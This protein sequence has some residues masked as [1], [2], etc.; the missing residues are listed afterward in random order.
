M[1]QNISRKYRPKTFEDVVG[2]N[3]IK[4]TLENEVVSG[5]IAHAYLF[6]GPRGIGKTS[7]ARIL[8]KSLK[9]EQR[10]DKEFEPCNKCGSCNEINAGKDMDL[11][12]IDAATHTQVDKVRE[13]IVENINFP[14]RN[15]YK[16]FIIDEVHML[17]T[18][19]FNALLKTLEEPPE[20]AVFVLCTTESHKIP[21]TII[22]RCQRFDF[23]KVSAEKIKDKLVNICQ[24]EKLKVSDEVLKLIAIRSGGYVRDAESLLGQITVLLSER[25]KEITI[26]DVQA[27]LP[28]SDLH[29]VAKIIDLLIDKNAAEGISLV[30]KLINDGVDLERF[31]ED[32]IDYL[33]KLSLVL[34][35]L[36]EKD[37]S[38]VVLPTEI[39]SQLS[40][41]AEKTN[42]KQATKM[43]NVF[44]DHKKMFKQ[45]EIVQLPIE[46]AIIEICIGANNDDKNN[47]KIPPTDGLKLNNDFASA[48]KVER[49]EQ[50]KNNNSTE[51]GFQNKN[52]AKTSKD[53]G[54]NLNKNSH[55]QEQTKDNSGKKKQIINNSESEEV[56]QKIKDEWLNIIKKSCEVNHSLPLMLKSCYPLKMQGNQLKL[57]FEFEIHAK[58]IDEIKR[59]QAAEKIFSEF[60]GID[61]IIKP[62]VV[63]ADELQKIKQNFNPKPTETEAE[64]NDEDINALAESFGGKVVE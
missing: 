35:G 9:C 23:K 22:S 58:Q 12:E 61:I 32:L 36:K 27:V 64:I 46:L 59:K 42:I 17:S 28:R 33:R 39:Q 19:A 57:G 45:T 30:D 49:A 37:P 14:P 25:K 53:H 24:Q 21:E 4:I 31:A 11:I 62:E 18:A 54:N 52:Q 20:Y 43:I 34:V 50:E 5:Q 29:S 40:Q 16:I 48:T 13:N 8:A 15:K 1:S 44:L 60:A 56:F 3:H 38:I 10:K 2:Q 6:A 41:Q 7:L 51:N 47:K 26:D 55:T 63:G